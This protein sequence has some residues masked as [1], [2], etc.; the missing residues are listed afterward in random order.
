MT[1]EH[2]KGTV[3]SVLAKNIQAIL[4]RATTKDV[5]FLATI[6]HEMRTPLNGIIGV[7]DLMTHQYEEQGLNLDNFEIYMKTLEQSCRT[8][9]SVVNRLQNISDL[10]SGET[11]ENTLTFDLEAIVTG[12]SQTMQLYTFESKE[13]TQV[14]ISFDPRIPRLIKADLTK[15]QQI[16]T[17]L[18]TVGALVNTNKQVDL[19]VSL[20]YLDKDQCTIGVVVKSGSITNE[21]YFSLQE[22]SL[23]DLGKLEDADL[24]ESYTTNN[25]RI[26]MNICKKFLEE[27]YST[28]EVT[29]EGDNLVFTFELAV[30]SMESLPRVENQ[31]ISLSEVSVL[32]A[33]DNIVNLLVVTRMLKYLGVKSTTAV[34]GTEVVRCIEN[35]KHYDMIF[36]DLDMPEMDG[37]EATIH[38]REKMKDSIA[39]IALTANSTNDAKKKCRAV[40]MN[41]FFTKP[42]TIQTLSEMIH[43]WF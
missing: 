1:N 31:K 16:L 37:Y 7:I 42:I 15:I 13:T 34:D 41:D 20:L 38:I 30:E 22:E 17:N 29:R 2:Q 23:L 12:V 8:L 32:V 24:F 33:D 19:R 5:N 18:C 36:M 25:M 40:G 26:T 27:L 21:E 14:N 10:Q 35:G 43:K 28:L 3:D 11:K 4:K 39:I 6:S 9:Q